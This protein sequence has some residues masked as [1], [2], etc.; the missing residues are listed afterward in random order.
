MT[1]NYKN[2]TAKAPKCRGHQSSKKGSK[3]GL[4]PGR[5]RKPMPIPRNATKPPAATTQSESPFLRPKVKLQEIAQ[6]IRKLVQIEGKAGIQIKDLTVLHRKIGE[7]IGHLGL[8]AKQIL[9]HGKLMEWFEDQNLGISYTTF[10]RFMRLAKKSPVMNF[11]SDAS[12][13]QA[14]SKLDIKTKARTD[15]P[16]NGETDRRRSKRYTEAKFVAGVESKTTYIKAA[17]VL[18]PL[19][20]FK[21][22]VLIQLSTGLAELIEA[23]TALKA[24]VEEAKLHKPDQ[25][26]V[27]E[28]GHRPPTMMRETGDRPAESDETDD[29]TGTEEDSMETGEISQNILK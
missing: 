10:G 23:C 15:I 9:G 6:R 24:K 11:P 21:A 17:V 18:A 22:E 28:G 16:E 25:A 12:L 27:N 3:P 4:K 29:Q 5:G 19:G 1:T 20:E 2:T 13:K 26:I 14:W 8:D 7:D